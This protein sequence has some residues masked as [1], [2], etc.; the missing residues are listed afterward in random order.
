MDF[1][2]IRHEQLG[3]VAGITANRPAVLN[4]QSRVTTC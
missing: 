4:A 3:A 1:R 2:T